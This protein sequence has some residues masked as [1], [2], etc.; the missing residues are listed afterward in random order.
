MALVDLKAIC[1]RYEAQTILRGADFAIEERERVAIVGRN[2]SGKT[3]LMKIVAGILEADSGDRMAQNLITIEALDQNPVLDENLTVREAIE[4]SLTHITAIKDEYAKLTQK[5]ELESDNKTLNDQLATLGSRLDFLG[6][7][8]L[9]EQIEKIITR[10]NLKELQHSKISTLSGGEKRRVALGAIMLKKP[11]LAL[12]DE[13]TNH[14]DVYMV[15]FLE[16]LILESKSAFLII[17]HDRYFIEQIA[18]RTIEIEDGHL[19]SFKGGYNLYLEQKA[20]M[21]E[22]MTK[23]HE[24]LVK[25]LKSEQEWLNRGVKARLKRNMGRVEKIKQ[26]KEEA[27]KNPSIIRR[28]KLELEREQK[29]FNREDGVNRKKALFEIENL[30]IN[31]CQKTLIKP[32]SAR[33]LQQ[34]KIA[35]SGRN[36]NGKTTLL[37]TL[38]GRLSAT[39]GI[40]KIGCE[41]I[42]YFDQDRSMLDDNKNLLE[43][44]CPN[45]GDH[46][47]ARGAS[48][49][50]YGYMKNWLFPKEFLDKKIGSLSGGEK[51]RVALALLFAKRYDCLIL[52]EPTNDLDI[53]TINILEEYLQSY[54]GALLFV[55]HDRFFIDKIASKLWLIKN[56]QTISEELC[57]YSDYLENEALLEEFEKCAIEAEK[58]T[59]KRESKRSQQK[60]SYKDQRLYDTLPIEID[61]LEKQIKAIESAMF[62]GVYAQAELVEQNQ[63][64][65]ALKES[66][67]LKVETYFELEARKENYA[68]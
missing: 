45:G 61:G 36:G 42:G 24:T 10:F 39:G 7:W 1:K 8:N 47:N 66:L 18:T 4:R 19:R 40:V 59:P 67:E 58:P 3:T 6:A 13:P 51:N 17:S 62:E 48:V 30:S 38:L 37:L 20:A 50:V 34:D 28:I 31:V 14:L 44:F 9:S 65:Q 64:L 5:L 33:I 55:S 26:M 56:D 52:D 22:S 2:G 32:F 57:S 21:L 60:L 11:D 23:S 16:E 53:P 25:Q 46:I 12:L 27:K 35:I 41:S 54:Q 49:H 63:T 15:K 29:A 43:T 68:S